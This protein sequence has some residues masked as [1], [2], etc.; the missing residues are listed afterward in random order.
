LGELLGAIPPNKVSGDWAR[1]IGLILARLWRCSP[2]ETLLGQI[3][4]T[5]R[6]LLTHYAPKTKSVEE[7]LA[8]NNPK[9]A[10]EYYR[11]ALNILLEAG[12]I[13]P[14]GDAAKE[15]TPEKMLESLERKGWSDVWLNGT[16]GICPGAK[17]M[18]PVERLAA[19]SPSRKPKDLKS[20]PKRPRK[21]PKTS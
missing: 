12:L 1:S 16:S 13:A 10:L 8:S 4:P 2:R 9:R 3:N 19:A 5:R 21:A 15:V 14:K 7:I 17:W 20:K 6:E 11:D 18:P